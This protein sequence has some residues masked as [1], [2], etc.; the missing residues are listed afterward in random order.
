MRTREPRRW[1]QSHLSSTQPLLFTSWEFRQK[2][3]RWETGTPW[4]LHLILLAQGRTGTSTFKIQLI[5]SYKLLNS[6]LPA[7]HHMFER[8]IQIL[9]LVAVSDWKGEDFSLLFIHFPCFPLNH[10]ASSEKLDWSS[11]PKISGLYHSLYYLKIFKRT[12]I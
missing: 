9:I 8:T 5:S 12:G 6:Q 2:E 7:R 1:H 3:G 4:K 11:S 10:H